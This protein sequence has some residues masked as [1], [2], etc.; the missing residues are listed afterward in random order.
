MSTTTT[1]TTPS[2]TSGEA[3]SSAAPKTE[4]RYM[5]FKNKRVKELIHDSKQPES[6][7]TGIL[8]KQ[9]AGRIAKFEWDR[10]SGKAP[11]SFSQLRT[12]CFKVAINELLPEFRYPEITTV[13]PPAVDRKALRKFA[14][15]Y[16]LKMCIDFFNLFTTLFT[17]FEGSDN[18][19][20]FFL[21]KKKDRS[22]FLKFQEYLSKGL[23]FRHL[24]LLQVPRQ[25]YPH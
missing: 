18:E 1:T 23:I 6:I 15:D 10:D 2:G 4:S 7:Y 12:K 17:S 3:A 24:M 5:M 11:F 16:T 9:D 13:P 14:Y 20:V 19:N 8:S 21:L 22:H 25:Q